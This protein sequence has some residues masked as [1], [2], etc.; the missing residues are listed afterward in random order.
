MKIIV[1]PDSFKEC[2]P[3]REVAAVM[4]DAVRKRWPGADV[5]ALP[6]ADGGEG[7][8]DVLAPALGAQVHTALVRDPL[9]RPIEARFG[10]AGDT[11]I[12]EVAQDCGLQLLTPAERHPLQAN[13]LGVGELLLAAHRLGCRHFLVGLGGSATC[14]GGAGLLAA[15]GINSLKDSSFELLCDVDAPFVGPQGAARVFA[16]QKGA[17]PADVEVLE[18]RME[19]LSAQWLMETG[20]DVRALS[21]AGAAGGLGGALMAHFG[22]RKVSGIQRVLDL[23]HFREAAVGAHLILTGEGRSDRQ[24]LQGKVPYGVLQQASGIPVALLSGRIEDREALLQAGFG[25]LVEVTPRDLPLAQALDPSMAAIL[26]SKAVQRLFP[27]A[28]NQ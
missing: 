12:I 4:A 10:V 27:T 14:D 8:L 22:A 28:P 24:T 20:L 16:P 15:T 19:A 7:T 6:L 5:V 11:A 26:L 13:T 3:S 2:M 25:P 9:G 21:G 17:T 18:G 1:A 23:V